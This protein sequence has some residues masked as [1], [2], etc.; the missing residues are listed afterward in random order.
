MQKSMQIDESIGMLLSPT[1]LPPPALEY[2]SRTS[3]SDNV[4]AYVIQKELFLIMSKAENSTSD[5]RMMRDLNNLRA[6]TFESFTPT[7]REIEDIE[8][9]MQRAIPTLD[10]TFWTRIK[11]VI[12]NQTSFRAHLKDSGLRRDEIREMVDIRAGNL[13]AKEQGGGI[14]VFGSARLGPNTHDYQDIQW[15][16]RTL[17]Q[18]LVRDDGRTE[19]IVTGGGPAIMEAANLGAAEGKRNIL[20]QWQEEY[21]IDRSNI[22]LLDKIQTL[23]SRIKN[24]GF[25]IT[26]PF[27]QGFCPFLEMNL[28]IKNFFARRKAMFAT[29]TGRSSGDEGAPSNWHGNHPAI[30]SGKGGLGTLDEISEALCLVQ[31]K[32]MPH[33]FTYVIGDSESRKW[34]EIMRIMEIDGTISSA[35][36]NLI[37]LCPSP[38]RALEEYLKD[39]A[40]PMPDSIARAIHEKSNQDR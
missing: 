8:K 37:K 14:L 35:D 9:R 36:C 13:I 40:I 4:V 16:T 24:I 3:E 7:K 25:R 34:E 20:K 27:E 29:A 18:G 15:L 5:K 38:V 6:K 23:R 30:F 33:I 12:D 26:L 17:V 19:R 2:L 32:K 31:C 21:E 10:P 1:R 22:R 28:T 39:Y 11:D